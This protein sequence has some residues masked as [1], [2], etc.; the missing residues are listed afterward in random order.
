MTLFVINISKKKIYYLLFHFMWPLHLICFFS[1]KVYIKNMAICHAGLDQQ[2]ITL[3]M[4][5]SNNRQYLKAMRSMK[6]AKRPRESATLLHSIKHYFLVQN[7]ASSVIN[8]QS[9]SQVLLHLSVSLCLLISALSVDATQYYYHKAL[10]VGL[11]LL[12]M[13]YY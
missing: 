3:N 7:S 9:Q 2:F 5:T 4:F 10:L 12:C 8:P 6:T 11:V 13:N 1:K